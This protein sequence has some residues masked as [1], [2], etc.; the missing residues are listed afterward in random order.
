MGSRPSTPEVFY[1][2]PLIKVR[3]N[4]QDFFFSGFSLLDNDG[5]IPAFDQKGQRI[6]NNNYKIPRETIDSIAQMYF[7]DILNDSVQI[8]NGP[9]AQRIQLT[10]RPPGVA[11]GILL[12]FNP[13]DL[14][15]LCRFPSTDLSGNVVPHPLNHAQ[16]TRTVKTLLST[17]LPQEVSSKIQVRSVDGRPDDV[18]I[19][20]GC[21]SF[22]FDVYGLLYR[23]WYL[24]PNDTN[25]QDT[26]AYKDVHLPENL[27]D[28]I[29]KKWQHSLVSFQKFLTFDRD[30]RGALIR[31]HADYIESLTKK[32]TD[33]IIRYVRGDLEHM[34]YSG[35]QACFLRDRPTQTEVED[36]TVPYTFSSNPKRKRRR[37]KTADFNR[38]S[39]MDVR[40]ITSTIHAAPRP[41]IGHLTVYRGLYYPNFE[42]S[43]EGDTLY[44][45]S[46]MSTS[47]MRSVAL[48]FVSDKTCCLVELEL[49]PSQLPFLCIFNSFTRVVPMFNEFEVLLPP[50]VMKV[51]RVKYVDIMQVLT[52]MEKRLLFHTKPELRQ[53]TTWTMRIMTVTPVLPYRTSFGDTCITL[54]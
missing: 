19:V 22:F 23:D 49:N 34:T 6:P 39:Q 27:I 20:I 14:L 48:G 13:L 52:P 37:V 21:D 24:P 11:D 29:Q 25:L 3:V 30:P 5:L 47:L 53:R 32:Q 45:P 17:L 10:Y 1:E 46:I 35:K 7:S 15:F 9:S 16:L 50:V 18:N 42:Q 28:M 54:E 12:I 36:I 2:R 41:S 33:P 40:S 31:L 38:L 26:T 44:H 4:G 8:G 51:N 43:K